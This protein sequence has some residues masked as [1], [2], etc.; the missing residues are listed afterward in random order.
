[1]RSAKRQL[2]L[3]CLVGKDMCGE[4]SEIDQRKVSTKKWVDCSLNIYEI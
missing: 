3:C 1:M 4:K 2:V